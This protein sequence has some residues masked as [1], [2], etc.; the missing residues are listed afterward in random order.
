MTDREKYRTRGGYYLAIRDSD[1]AREQYQALVEQFPADSTGLSNLAVASSVRRDMK[2][3]LELGRK[4]SAIY[5]NHVLRRNNVALFAMY[6]GEFETAEKE[7]AGVLELNKDFAKAYLV[8]ALV[9]LATGRPA[10]AEATWQRLR[11]ISTTGRDFAAHGRADLAMYEG[12]LADAARLLEEEIATPPEGR[13]T[14]TT[15]RLIVSL[16]EVRQLQGRDAEALKLAEEALKK[17]P[18]Q[19]IALLAGRIF[20]LAGKPQLGLDIAADLDKKLDQEAQMYARLLAGEAD[21]KRGDARAAVA[22]FGAAQKISDSWIGHYGLGRAYLAAGVHTDAQTEFDACL[23]RKG[24][25]TTML[26][27]DI[28]TYRFMASTRYYMA[29][30]QEGQGSP[31]ATAAAKESYKAFLKIKEKGDEQGLVAD[32]RRRVALK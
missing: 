5:P 13:S 32:A 17:S 31:A 27:D 19:N 11:G 2:L 28:P 21:L 29:R 23:S 7:A 16:A 9:Q 12:R 4:A 14:T 30:A 15:A 22:N 18:E 1:K 24:E 20:I 25:A 26:L 6:A 8:M 3:A 10:E